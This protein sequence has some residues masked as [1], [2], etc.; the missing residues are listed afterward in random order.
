LGPNNA[1]KT[2]ISL[3]SW[4]SSDRRTRMVFITYGIDE[5]TLRDSLEHLT[6]EFNAAT[7]QCACDQSFDATAVCSAMIG[8][9]SPKVGQNDEIT[10]VANAPEPTTVTCQ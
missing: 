2:P 4:P 8:S 3:K 6:E 9:S 10:Y 5:K 1:P 7:H